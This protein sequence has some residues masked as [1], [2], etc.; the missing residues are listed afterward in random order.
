MFPVL[1]VNIERALPP[2]ASQSLFCVE[3]TFTEPPCYRIINDTG[4]QDGRV[5]VP[6]GAVVVDTVYSAAVCMLLENTPQICHGYVHGSSAAEAHPTFIQEV[7]LL[8][9]IR[10]LREWLTA[11]DRRLVQNITIQTVAYTGGL[12]A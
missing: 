9:A 12:Q 7:V 11:I 2:D 4:V 1:M 6:A 10:A 3:T 8:Q 5:Q